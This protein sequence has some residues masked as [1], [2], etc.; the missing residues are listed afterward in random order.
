[1]E[2]SPNSYP[3]TYSTLWKLIIRPHRDIYSPSS[4]IDKIFSF[5]DKIYLRKDYTI[6]NQKGLQLKCSLIE[7][8]PD[9]RPYEKMPIIIYLHSNSSS[10]LEG[11]SNVQ[12]LLRKNINLF[13]FD[14]SGSG[15]SEGEYIS[16]GYNEKDDLK[17]V[18]DFVIKLPGV[19]KIGLWGRSMGAATALMY[20]PLDN[21]ITCLGIDSPFSEFK[22]LAKQ[23]CL[24]YKG[25]PNFI[26]DLV[27]VFLKKSIKEKIGCDIEE[28]NPIKGVKDI[29]IPGFF[30]HGIKDELIPVEHTVNIVN[31]YSGI[32]E[33]NV[34]E[35]G[36]NS[37]RPRHVMRKLANFFYRY[38]YEGNSDKSDG[39][40][41][42]DD[43]DSKI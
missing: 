26:V 25:I 34:V 41:I 43:E 16:L 37:K 9:N 2:S 14:F 33:I 27:F 15:L 11:L 20:T 40:V 28:I 39:D 24:S 10:R 29:K 1:M 3:F 23:L 13:V 36:H 21:R 22:L 30:I 32:K 7:P 8:D 12:Y 35:G 6:I 31:Q 18:I 19:S 38:L 42:E 4:L 17:V 5:D